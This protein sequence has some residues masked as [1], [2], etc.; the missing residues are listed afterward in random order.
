MKWTTVV[1]LIACACAVGALVRVNSS[2]SRRVSCLEREKASLFKEKFL[3]VD[4]PMTY[5]EKCLLGNL[6]HRIRHAYEVEGYQS[7]KPYA[8]ALT[9]MRKG[10]GRDDMGNAEKTLKRVSHDE[11]LWTEEIR[12]FA[13]R[14][15][16][17]RYLDIQYDLLMFLGELDI[18][19]RNFE[20]VSAPE[21]LA[22]KK[23]CAYCEHFHSS[24][25]RDWCGVAEE[26]R[27]RLISH[28]ESSSGFTRQSAVY[29]MRL[30]TE[31]AEALSPGKGLSRE[32]ALKLGR[33]IAEG[34]VRSGYTPKWLDEFK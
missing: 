5:T 26:Y 19:R 15:E 24:S 4:E 30:N 2:L 7:L 33:M 1:I 32:K 34:L 6:C 3:P 28:I 25:D 29:Q 17:A 11:F 9:C 22:Y 18:E 10:A 8:E 12:A 14:D 21:C 13:S 31:Y 16:F 27:T 20:T 23:I